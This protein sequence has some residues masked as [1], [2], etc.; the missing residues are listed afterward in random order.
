MAFSEDMV[1]QYG[2]RADRSIYRMYVTISQHEWQWRFRASA[3][4][5]PANLIKKSTNEGNHM[6]LKL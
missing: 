6:K 4:E 2:T 1:G 3:W 5:F